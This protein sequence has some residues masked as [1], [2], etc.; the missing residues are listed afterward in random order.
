MGT[1]QF[2]IA[3]DGKEKTEER[4]SGKNIRDQKIYL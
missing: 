4:R 1:G 3:Y 2:L